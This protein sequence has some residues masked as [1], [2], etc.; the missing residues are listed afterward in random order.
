MSLIERKLEAFI[1]SLNRS[2]HHH[3]LCSHRYNCIT[4]SIIGFIQ[5]FLAGFLLQAGFKCLGSFAAILKNPKLIIKLLKSPVNSEL[6]LFLGFYVFIF[7]VISCSLRWLT[8]QNDKFHSL[9]AGFFSGWSMLFYKSSTIALYL[10]FKLLETLWF[11]GVKNKKL[12]L[13]KSFDVI[14]YNLISLFLF[15]K[16]LVLVD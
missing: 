16:V 6:G 9:I 14:L 1:N 10:N 13:V 3:E 15:S 11:I 12:P 4:H 5:R 7:R 8:N 2:F